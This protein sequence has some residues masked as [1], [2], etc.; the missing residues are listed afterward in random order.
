MTASTPGFLGFFCCLRNGPNLRV[1]SIPSIS[2]LMLEISR[3]AT[4]LNHNRHRCGKRSPVAATLVFCAATDADS[5]CHLAGSS[6]GTPLGIGFDRAARL[7]L[8]P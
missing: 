1:D 5:V 3:D 2:H 8:A 6:G 7:P 4:R